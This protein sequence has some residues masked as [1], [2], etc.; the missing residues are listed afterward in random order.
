MDQLNTN[1]SRSSL[2]V[3]LS[4][5]GAI[6]ILVCFFL[7]W[8]EVSCSGKKIIGSGLTFALK[9]AP[10][11]LIPAFAILVLLLFIWYWNGLSLTWFKILLMT[12]AALGI[13][14]LVFTYISIEQKLSGFVVRRITSH[15]IKG[16]LIGTGIGFVSIILSALALRTAQRD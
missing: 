4:P 2:A 3:W 9:A 6:V 14:M 12:L 16:G 5:T 13:L 11:W 15:Q 7:P 1:P 8:L 10:L